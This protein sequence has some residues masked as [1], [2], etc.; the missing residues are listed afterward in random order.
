MS[1]LISVYVMLTLVLVSSAFAYTYTCQEGHFQIDVPEGWEN[2]VG[3][4]DRKDEGQASF[5]YVS[6]DN[7][8]FFVIKWG[9]IANDYSLISAHDKVV[10]YQY[11]PPKTDKYLSLKEAETMNIDN[12]FIINFRE[13]RFIAIFL[14]GKRIYILD[15]DLG[16]SGN[17]P[18]LDEI[19]IR[20]FNSFR[21][22]D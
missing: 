21:A 15:S 10:T 9:L 17:I 12:G 4:F 19:M 14:K 18:H 11:D 13:Y 2:D 5:R 20:I 22:L 1:K 3:L 7:A 6:G 16:M 8:A